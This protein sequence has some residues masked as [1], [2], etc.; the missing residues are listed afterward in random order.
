M[1]HDRCEAKREG[2]SG[3]PN[4]FAHAFQPPKWTVPAVPV[5]I[6]RNDH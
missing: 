5:R 4:R 6:R 3:L 2:I 1:N